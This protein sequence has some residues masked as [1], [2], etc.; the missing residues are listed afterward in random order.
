M[1]R[2]DLLW[3]GPHSYET[4]KNMNGDTDYGLYQIY[5]PHPASGA[6]TLLYIGKAYDQTFRARFLGAD[7]RWLNSDDPWNDN[8]TLMRIFTGRIHL[9]NDMQDQARDLWETYVT[10]AERLLI[11][12]HAPPW[13]AQ[14][15]GGIGRTA[16]NHEAA[17]YHVLNWGVRAS[18]L[19]EV[20]GA[21]HAAWEDFEQINVDP[22]Q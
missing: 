9:T 7:K 12:S 8:V 11:A 17:N 1:E 2:I 3:T 14:G 6:D 5:G 4:V 21:R 10:N 22:I 15:V 16:E 13:N 19:P 18:L 20:S